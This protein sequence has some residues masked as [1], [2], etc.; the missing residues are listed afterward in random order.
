MTIWI[1]VDFENRIIP[2]ES[3]LTKEAAFRAS[4]EWA[5]RAGRSIY[6]IDQVPIETPQ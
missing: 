1:N 3:Y 5:E 2:T 4:K 6:D